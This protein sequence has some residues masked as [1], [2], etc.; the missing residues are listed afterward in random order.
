MVPRASSRS[1]LLSTSGEGH[2]D[3]AGL[4]VLLSLLA[5]RYFCTDLGRCGTGTLAHFLV[6]AGTQR[7]LWHRSMM[8]FKRL[9][10]QALLSRW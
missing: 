6:A 8:I 9:G 4:A 10:M 3:I 1:F 5:C 7:G 2:P